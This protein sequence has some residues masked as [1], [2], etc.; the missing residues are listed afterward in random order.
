MEPV[1][2]TVAPFLIIEDYEAH[3]HALAAASSA[4]TDG[5]ELA[6]AGGV[7]L[8]E[9]ELTGVENAPESVYLIVS[10]DAV[11]I[12]TPFARVVDGGAL[13]KE[14]GRADVAGG[15][16]DLRVGVWAPGR[17]VAH[18]ARSVSTEELLDGDLSLALQPVRFSYVAFCWALV[19]L[20]VPN[21]F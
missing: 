18:G 8:V 10:L 4:S 15:P 7:T 3:E 20:I 19:F 9:L 17:L 11:K 12:R 16:L 5:E 14:A 21:I 2:R 1:Q 6:D 13:F